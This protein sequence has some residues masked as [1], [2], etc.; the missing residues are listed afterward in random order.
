MQANV[1]VTFKNGL[2]TLV[3]KLFRE[4]NKVD[5]GSV[6]ITGRITFID[7]KSGDAISINGACAGNTEIDIDVDTNPPTPKHFPEGNINFGF[8]VL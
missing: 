1:D 7:A 8:D 2:G 5:E 4:G 6:D 3:A